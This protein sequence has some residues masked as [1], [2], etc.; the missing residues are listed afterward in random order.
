[1]K[2]GAQQQ[3]RDLDRGTLEKRS[4]QHFRRCR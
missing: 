2:D 4:V 1:V 3:G